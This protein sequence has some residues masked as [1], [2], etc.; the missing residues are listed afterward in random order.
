MND[1]QT[2]WN[3]CTTADTPT[4]RYRAEQV[5]CARFH[6]YP[7]HPPLII[8]DRTGVTMRFA[9]PDQGPP[10]APAA[11]PGELTGEQLKLL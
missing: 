2:T 1:P 4:E 6:T 5:Y 11:E 3:F 9:L 7:A 10:Q 8:K